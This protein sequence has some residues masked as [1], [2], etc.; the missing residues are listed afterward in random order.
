M[1]KWMNEERKIQRQVNIPLI[2]SKFMFT[3][4]LCIICR[5][6]DEFFNF[7]EDVQFFFSSISEDSFYQCSLRMT[8]TS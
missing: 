3:S 7:G 2:S 1:G 6:Q 5:W 4:K 8:L